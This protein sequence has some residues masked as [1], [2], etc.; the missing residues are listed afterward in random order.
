MKKQLIAIL[1]II[2]MLAGCSLTK[3]D[4]SDSGT[5]SSASSNEITT[6]IDQTINTEYTDWEDENPIYINLSDDGITADSMTGISIDGLIITIN[7][8]GTYVFTGT[9]SDGQIIVEATSDEDVRIVLNNVNIYSSDSAPIYIKQAQDA[10]ITLAEGSINYLSDSTVYTLDSDE[11]PTATIFSKDDLKINGTGTLNITANYNNAIQ[12]KDDLFILSGTINITAVD[13]GIVGK[14]SVR[15]AA[16]IITVNAQKDAIKS[17][18]ASD[19]TKGY[20]LINGGEFNLTSGG[21]GLAAETEVVINEGTFNIITN[22]NGLSDTTSYKGIKAVTGITINN[23]NFNITSA[24]DSIHSNGTIII[25]NGTFS[26]TSD[27]DGIH[28]DT[29]ITINNGIIDI[30]KSYEGIESAGITINGGTINVTASDDGINVAGGVDQSSQN[31]RQGQNSF[32]STATMLLTVN[33]GYVT[34][35]AN[36]DGIDVNGSIVITGGEIYVNGPTANDNGALDYDGTLDISGGILLAIGS[37]GM[38]Q[39]PSSSSTQYSLAVTL[40]ANQTAGTK[41]TLQDEEGNTIFEY[42][43]LKPFASIIL[44]LPDLSTDTPYTILLNDTEFTTVSLSG[45]VTYVTSSGTSD[46]TQ[47][48]GNQGSAPGQT[49][50]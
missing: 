37:T 43:A 10:T 44:S 41:I 34:V 25:N 42:T 16:G 24:D 19:T 18:N 1:I 32:T 14:D 36:G 45:V 47:G 48:F 13:D 15:I 35:I 26:I 9:L 12:S 38:A 5:D 20:I 29:A 23:G 3:T 46:S 31:G 40:S 27:D 30:T 49:R 33:G 21:D 8:A 2:L 28:A 7:R 50:N 11:E 6:T 4:T 39:T 17:T 22:G